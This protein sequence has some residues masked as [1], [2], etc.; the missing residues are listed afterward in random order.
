MVMRLAKTESI[1]S[2]ELVSSSS[3]QMKK[4]ILMVIEAN[5]NYANI[6]AKYI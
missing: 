3:K 5:I 1:W 4:S 2:K 6:I